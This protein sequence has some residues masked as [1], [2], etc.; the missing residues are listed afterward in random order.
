MG[1]AD[2]EM[3][4]VEP[5]KPSLPYGIPYPP[6]LEATQR[7]NDETF[8]VT[9]WARHARYHGV[10]D[11]PNGNGFEVRLFNEGDPTGKGK[12]FPDDWDVQYRLGPPS[13]SVRWNSVVEKWGLQVLDKAG[14]INLN[15]NPGSSYMHP[16]GRFAS[17]RNPSGMDDERVHPVFRREVW[18]NL[19]EGDYQTIMPALLL[20]SAFLDEPTTLCLF[21]AISVPADQMTTIEDPN[22]KNCKR[23]QVPETLTEPEQWA[24]FHK[25]SAM[26]QWTSFYWESS[27]KLKAEGGALG[28]CRPLVHKDGSD[29]TASGPHTRQSEIGLSVYYLE[30]LRAFTSRTNLVHKYYRYKARKYFDETLKSAG[31]LDSHRPPETCI[32]SAGLRTAFLFAALLVHEFAHAFSLAYFERVDDSEPREPWVADNRSN[33][34]GHAMARFIIGGTP[35]APSFR[36]IDSSALDQN[37]LTDA[38]AQF[39]VYFLDKWQQW[40]RPGDERLE[41][42]LKEG[43]QEDQDAPLVYWPVPQRQIYDYFTEDLWLARVPKY[44]LNALKMVKIRDWG[45]YYYP[46]PSTKDPWR[47]A[48]LR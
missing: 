42:H 40:A 25:I 31:V 43:A 11:H 41:Q 29:I 45:A 3:G 33:E 39:G 34:L 15:S 32:D 21:H 19:S 16:I 47:D 35:Y 27:H 24:V 30:V 36:S 38:Y 28:F 22:L 1:D 17:K 9:D 18:Q 5:T 13:T 46:G 7:M 44:G 37:S 8:E 4:G 2:V 6:E 26:R 48:T 23:L 20:A 10:R 12:W 14:F